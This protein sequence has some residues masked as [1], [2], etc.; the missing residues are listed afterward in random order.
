MSTAETHPA[1]RVVIFGVGA[2]AE[3]AHFYLTHDS[4]HEVV[5]FTVDGEYLTENAFHDLPVVAFEAVEETFAPGDAAMFLP[6][7][8]KRMNHVRAE[9]V[10]AAK[11]RG[12]DLISYVSSKATT[13]PGF[14]C[15]EN[16]FILEDNTIQPFV[17][18]GDDVILWSGNHIGHH[19]VI[20]DHVMV[21]SQVVISGGCTIEP[22]CFFGVNSTI[23][24][25]T[26][27]ARETLVGAGVTILHDTEPYSVYKAVDAEPAGFRSDQVRSISHKSG[28]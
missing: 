28:G 23:R 15:G 22:H 17:R 20:G 12:Y 11:A 9:R 19:S 26:V 24:D 1:G 25:E 2:I 8:F 27:I 6:I 7:S 13:F 16:C 14:E 10:A 3:L 18:V 4:S 21:T 5:G